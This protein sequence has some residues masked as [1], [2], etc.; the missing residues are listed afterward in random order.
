MTKV[1]PKTKLTED[2]SVPAK[3]ADKIP[4]KDTCLNCEHKEVGMYKCECGTTLCDSCST[5]YP[6]RKCGVKKNG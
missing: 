1:K 2:L 6:C 5:H 3:V 4:V